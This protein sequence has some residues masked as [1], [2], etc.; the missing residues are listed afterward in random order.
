[1]K[2]PERLVWRGD[3]VWDLLGPVFLRQGQEQRDIKSG[4]VNSEQ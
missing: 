3:D 1:M 4:T 2:R